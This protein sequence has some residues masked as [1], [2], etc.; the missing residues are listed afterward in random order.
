MTVT[1]DIIGSNYGRERK[2][3]LNG[4]NK[5]MGMKEIKRKKREH[6]N[7]TTLTESLESL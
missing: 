1:P 2:V 5:S 7:Q 6:L 4:T 3:E